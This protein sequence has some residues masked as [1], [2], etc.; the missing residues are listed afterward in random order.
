M[1]NKEHDTA[2]SSGIKQI[3]WIRIACIIGIGLIIAILSY[4]Q[5]AH[6]KPP[7]A[8]CPGQ[9]LSIGYASLSEMAGDS[10][11]IVLGTIEKTEKISYNGSEVLS[12]KLRIKEQIKGEYFAKGSEI[13]LCPVLAKDTYLNETVLVF[14]AG[15]DKSGLWSPLLGPQSIVKDGGNHHFK[16]WGEKTYNLEDVRQAAKK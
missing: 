4:L 13:N 7:H 15:K 1:L 5:A 12:P 10:P 11:S 9:G 3:V 16:V 8:M 2:P 6:P 14:L